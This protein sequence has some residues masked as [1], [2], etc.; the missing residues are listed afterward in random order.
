MTFRVSM[1]GL[2]TT[3]TPQTPRVRPHLKRVIGIFPNDVEAPETPY[4]AKV[5]GADRPYF[6][7]PSVVN[8][9]AQSFEDSAGAL[10]RNTASG[11]A[12]SI[13]S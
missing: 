4:Q 1:T 9:V 8:G 12:I 5:Y 13:D 6:A 10:Q 7:L 3:L 11:V 2:D